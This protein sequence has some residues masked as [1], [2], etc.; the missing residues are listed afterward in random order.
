MPSNRVTKANKGP[1][2]IEPYFDCPR[3]IEDRCRHESPMLGKGVGHGWR[4]PEL[5]EVV[6]ICDHLVTLRAGEL[7]DEIPREA[8]PV[9]L[10]LLV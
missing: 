2:D 1:H 7:E 5:C 9:A 4:K 8:R 6:A 10:Y 3:G